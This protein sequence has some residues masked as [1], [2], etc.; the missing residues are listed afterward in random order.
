MKLNASATA[1]R[2]AFSIRAATAGSASAHN[3]D[4]LFTGENVRS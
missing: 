1:A 4:T 2:W 3:V